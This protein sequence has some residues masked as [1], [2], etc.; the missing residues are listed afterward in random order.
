MATRILDCDL[1][2]IG[3]GGIGS[4]CAGKAIDL[5]PGKKVIVIEKA[6][7]PGGASI[8]AHG[9]QITDS[10]WQR[11]AGAQISEP[12]SIS[13]Q[14]WDWFVTKGGAEKYFM[15]K[16]TVKWG[17]TN[18]KW[19]ID[20]PYRIDKY[21]NLDDPSI[22]PGYWGS[23]IVD[24]MMECCRKANVPVLFDTPAK[25]FITDASGR[26]TGVMAGN[27]DGEI[28]I[29][30]KA[31]FIGAGG[32]GSNYKKCQ[33]LWPKIY[34]N[35]PMHN[36]CPPSLTGDL[37]DAAQ[38]AGAGIDLKNAGANVQ[39]P[40]HHPYSYAVVAM[41]RT[42]HMGLEINL[43]GERAVNQGGGG[44]G[45]ATANPLIYTIADQDIIEKAGP[46]AA[47]SV[48]EP[49]EHDFIKKNWKE[50]LEL[51]IAS[52]EKGR[53]GRHTTKADTLVELAMKLNI[54]PLVFLATVDKYNKEISSGDSQ[55]AGMGG[56]MG[57]PGG[58]QGGQSGLQ[59]MQGGQGAPGGG[60]GD[61]GGPQGMQGGQ[62]GQGVAQGGQGGGMGGM[63]GMMGGSQMPIKNGPFYAIFQQRFRQCTHGGIIVNAKHEVLDTKGNVMPGMYAGGDCTTEYTESIGTQTSS[64]GGGGMRGGPGIFGNYTAHQGGGMMGIPKGF[65]AAIN[66]A[67]YLKKA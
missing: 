30:F 6:K 29:N 11:K 52:D 22:G 56:M 12:K 62:S 46:A 26:V 21:R 41:T 49:Y 58:S 59:G 66:I 38:D 15:V 9:L 17:M 44:P 4:I 67:D 27:K 2:V 3:M 32:F 8:L 19:G 23:F 65:T 60:Q 51:E 1:V 28:Q 55:G 34:N 36:L 14:F 54:D 5:L 33:E 48:N 7:K 64:Q 24:K 63:G 18:Q 16:E 61:Q 45:Q 40:I 37:I 43:E 47:D 53:Y 35:I 13:G 20:M 25:R 42:G 10:E 31:C 57:M 39:G 50:E